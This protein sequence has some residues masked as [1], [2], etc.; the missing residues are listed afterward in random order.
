MNLYEIQQKYLHI[1][2]ILEANDGE[3][4]EEIQE[5]LTV[6]DEDFKEKCQNYRGIIKKF[7]GDIEEAK[8]EK[9]RIDAFI[10]QRTN[11]VESLK[12]AV[13]QA[14]SSRGL[15]EIDFGLGRKF[16]YLRSESVEILD[17]EVLDR[18]WV[19]IKETATPDKVAIKK[20]LKA[21]EDVSGAVLVE[22]RN[23]Q[24]K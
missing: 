2:Q 13:D 5:A 19:K 16:S 10:K 8:A 14:L 7:S 12:M 9:A 4:Q 18:K 6:N 3:M 17:E 11:N 1:L 15:T 21:G 23:L 24:I 20:A 22:K